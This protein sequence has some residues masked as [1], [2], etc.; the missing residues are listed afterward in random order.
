[1]Q[2]LDFFTKIQPVSDTTTQFFIEP[3]PFSFGHSLGNALR[4]TL[5]SSIEGFAVTQIR[6]KQVPHMFSP[7]PGVKESALE[8]ILNLKQL[9]F[10]PAKGDSFVVSFSQKGPGKV[11][12]GDIKGDIEVTNKDLYIAEIT[13]KDGQLD[14]ELVV[15]RGVGYLPSEEVEKKE[16]NFITVDAFFSP[17]K[18]VTYTV[19][20]ARVGRK[21]NADKLVLTVETDG[22]I[23]A[24]DA[25][26]EAARNL[27][28]V[29]EH[30]MLMK[31]ESTNAQLSPAM[32]KTV[33]AN[34]KKLE[35]IIIDELDLPSRVTNALLREKIETVKDLLAVKKDVLANM[36]GLGKKSVALI[37]EELQKLNLSL[38]E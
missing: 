24:K 16:N 20:E 38:T 21:A 26:L 25:L 34:D 14:I 2:Q 8:I 10:N 32:K 22:S 9:R 3:L 37:E 17:V 12:G 33:E 11:H 30:L 4:R 1:M 19:E 13:G 36:K 5:L 29:I 6:I 15:E 18:K 27:Q 35:E 23:E 28:S 7:I 31:S